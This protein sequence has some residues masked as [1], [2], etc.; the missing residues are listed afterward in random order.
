MRCTAVIT[1][2]MTG[3]AGCPAEFARSDPANHD[4][5]AGATAEV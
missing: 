5:K 2:A 1:L 3:V 4:D